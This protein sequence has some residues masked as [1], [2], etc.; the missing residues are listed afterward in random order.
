MPSLSP[1]DTHIQLRD[2]GSL[3]FQDTYLLG[4]LLP[5][6][7]GTV[8]APSGMLTLLLSLW[9]PAQSSTFHPH[10]PVV[11]KPK[12]PLRLPQLCPL[13]PFP[14]TFPSLKQTHNSCGNFPRYVLPHPGGKMQVTQL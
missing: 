8:T 14:L 11:Y 4:L 12:P 5:A 2:S 9:T 10:C 7:L 13:P 1:W 6:A 3:S